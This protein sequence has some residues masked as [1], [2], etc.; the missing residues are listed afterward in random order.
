MA[1]MNVELFKKWEGIIDDV[2]KSKIPIQFIK[3]IVCKLDGRRQH[4]INVQNLYKQGMKDEEVEELVGRKMAELDET[5]GLDNIE[6]ILDVKKIADEVQPYT[7]KL[8]DKL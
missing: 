8:L 1:S 7:D 6:F 3:K 5:I 2:E 4:T